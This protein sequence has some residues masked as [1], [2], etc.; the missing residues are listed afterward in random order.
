MGRHF[1]PDM[2]QVMKKTNG[3][4]VSHIGRSN[5][6]N[7]HLYFVKV[8][9]NWKI[10]GF[11][12]Y[13]R[14]HNIKKDISSLGFKKSLQHLLTVKESKACKALGADSIEFVGRSSRLNADI[15]IIHKNNEWK[16]LEY[17]KETE[18]FW[19]LKDE[20]FKVAC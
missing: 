3:N 17:D 8:N 4:D 13:K 16:I 14:I 9:A 12:S 15:Y 7:Y 1:S 2:W 10:V 18:S 5:F 11:D 19:T 6:L 20:V